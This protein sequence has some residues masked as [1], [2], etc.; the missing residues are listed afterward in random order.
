MPGDDVRSARPAAGG[1]VQFRFETELERLRQEPAWRAGS[2]NAI[3]LVKER[4]LR[5]VLALLHA[6]TRLDPHHAPGP[7]T[8]QVLSGRV[9]LGPG[10][11]VALE[12][13]LEHDVEAVEESALLL[14]L[15]AAG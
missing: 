12:S 2:R 8:L 3:T 6:G 10:V 7:L 11:L 15:P 5:V 4:G 1:L 9:R 14:T 13:A